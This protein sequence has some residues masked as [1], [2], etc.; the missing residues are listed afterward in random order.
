MQK[1]MPIA[2]YLLAAVFLALAVLHALKAPTTSSGHTGEIA[3][4]CWRHT[5][6][7]GRCPY[8]ALVNV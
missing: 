3:C 2:A 5:M 1:I 8:L 4:W 6:P 7:V